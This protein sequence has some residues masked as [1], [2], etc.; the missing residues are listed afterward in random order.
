MIGS[1]ASVLSPPPAVSPVPTP[2][3]TIN[4]QPVQANSAGQYIAGG[5]TLAAGSQITV[6]GQP[7]SLPLSGNAVIHGPST[8]AIAPASASASVVIAGFSV[9][10]NSAGQY[11]VGSQAL[12]PSSPITGAPSP[13]GLPTQPID[14]QPVTANS[15]SQ[16]IIGSQSLASGGAITLSSTTISLAPSACQV[17]V[18]GTTMSLSAP[19]TLGNPPPLT[20]ARPNHHR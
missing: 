10:P 7:I 4:S 9:T 2:F 20:I 19:R 1:T 3:V 16:Y 8:Q 12:A 5:Q 13:T 11:I 6:S 14:G 17:V 18:G 15:Q